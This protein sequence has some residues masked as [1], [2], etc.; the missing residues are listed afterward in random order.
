MGQALY[1]KYRSKNLADIVG[2]EHIT[3]TLEQAIK[4]NRISHAYLFTGPRGVGKTSIARI[5]A[6]QINNLPYDTDSQHIDIIEI[7]A[8]SNNG[9]EDMRDLRQKAYIT[10]TS[11][12]YKVYIIDEVHML[13]TPAFNG[14]LKTLEEPPAHIVFILATTEGHKLPA[15]IISRTQQYQFKPI[16]INQLI[17]HL[18]YIADKESI[19]INSEALK[20]I[21]SHGQGS[22]RD[23]IGLLDQAANYSLPITAESVNRLLGIPPNEVINQILTYLSVN[24]PSQLISFLNQIFDQGYNAPLIASKLSAKFRDQLI[25]NQPTI[26]LEVL[27]DLLANLL[28]V[29]ASRNAQ[30]YLEICLLKALPK[31][32]IHSPKPVEAKSIPTIDIIKLET[33]PADNKPLSVDK[34]TVISNTTIQDVFSQPSVEANKDKD[35]FWEEAITLLKTRYNTLYAIVRMAKVDY[36]EPSTVRLV[37]AYPFHQKRVNETKN[38]EIIIGILRQ[39]TGQ[40]LALVC[41]VDKSGLGQETTKLKEPSLEAISTIFG[42]GEMLGK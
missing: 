38:R 22:F 17:N 27:L 8:A 9:I 32:I 29:P 25:N 37:F 26:D 41:V 31:T 14:L 15:T 19:S 3:K 33:D 23:S 16:E 6:H 1:R 42:G 39:V 11:A 21:A 13:S 30:H 35:Q 40:E 4:T 34:P 5:L 36:S 2:Q 7:D 24:N 18:Q 28:D 20:V 10:P 12:K